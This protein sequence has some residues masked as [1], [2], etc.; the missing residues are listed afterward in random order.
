MYLPFQRSTQRLA[1]LAGG[2]DETPLEL[3]KKLEARKL[4]EKLP[5]THLSSARCVSHLLD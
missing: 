3:R 1:L 2:W 4:L 5:R